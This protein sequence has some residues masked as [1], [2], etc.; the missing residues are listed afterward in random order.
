MLGLMLS[1][2]ELQTAPIAIDFQSRRGLSVSIEGV[3]LSLGSFFQVY[4]PGWT[5]GHYSSNWNDQKI[6]VT[7]GGYTISGT[8]NLKLLDFKINVNRTSSGVSMAFDFTWNGPKQANLEIS[9]GHIWGPAVRYG[10]LLLDGKPSLPLGRQVNDSQR[11]EDRYFGPP[12][13]VLQFDSPLGKAKLTLDGVKGVLIDG[14]GLNADWTNGGEVFWLGSSDIPLVPKEPTRFTA[15]WVIEPKSPKPGTSITVRPKVGSA[16]GAYGPFEGPMP[17]APKPKS[18]A[19]GKGKAFG[20][21][22]NITIEGAQADELSPILALIQEAIGERWEGVGSSKRKIKTEVKKLGLRSGGYKLLVKNGQVTLT[23]QDLEGLQNGLWR[24]AGLLRASS[25]E[26]TI[27][28][29]ELTDEPAIDFRGIHLFVGPQAYEFQ[30]KMIRRVFGP[31]LLNQVVLQAERASWNT[32]RGTE[33]GWTMKKSDLEKLVKVYRAAGVDP[34]PLIQSFGHMGW[35]FTNGQNKDL[36]FNPEVPFSIDPRKDRTRTLLRALWKEVVELFDPKIMHFGLDEIDMR[37]WP[38]NP[39]LVTELWTLQ[40]KFLAELAKENGR[41]MMVWGDQLLAPGQAPDAMNG[42]NP[43]EAKARRDA[44]PRGAYIADWHYKNDANPTIYK[45]LGLFQSEGLI[46]VAS[47]WHRPLNIK[48]FFA[49]AAKSGAGALQTTWA[50]YE[51]NEANMIREFDQMVSYVLAGEYAWSN[52]PELPN[53]MPYTA[54]DLLRRL[55]GQRH[56]PLK[57]KA[58]RQITWGGK[59]IPTTIGNH[60]LAICEPIEFFS[61]IATME[62]PRPELVTFALDQ[63]AKMAV[64]AMSMDI[65]QTNYSSLATVTLTFADGSKITREILA[66]RDM[67]ANVEPKAS[68]YSAQAGGVFAIELTGLPKKLIRKLEVASKNKASNLKLHAISLVP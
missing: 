64:L 66:A 38:E 20:W 44:L 46:P 48:G 22:R 17:L 42:H 43:T 41:E 19:H 16:L 49:A 4:E 35:L 37:G 32:I 26:L 25:G 60:K 65:P 33:S 24:C 62:K 57:P 39:K 59:I 14:R 58:T 12:A 51:S 47:T 11:F 61:A 55:Y 52:R 29:I 8:D 53:R 23:G 7:A 63:S 18:V 6:E 68:L 31:M 27:P 28:P 34:T 15:E 50:G 13:S 5:K 56:V 54:D 1:F 3:P 45:S 9:F 10:E 67:R 2:I 40:T 21:S 36:M 30:S